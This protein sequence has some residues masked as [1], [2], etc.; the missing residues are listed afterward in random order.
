MLPLKIE[1]TK[2]INGITYNHLEKYFGHCNLYL[3]I[4]KIGKNHSLHFF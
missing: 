2:Y 4:F 1:F 3:N